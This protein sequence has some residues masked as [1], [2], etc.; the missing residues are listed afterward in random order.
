LEGAHI[1]G[2]LNLSAGTITNKNGPALNADELNLS[3]GMSCI[4]DF[5]ASGGVFL[6]G[7][8]IRGELD[9]T[10]AVLSGAVLTN[11]SRCAL[12]ADGLTV[13]GAM[14]CRQGFAANGEVSLLGARIGNQFDC[15]GGSFTNENGSALTG[16]G[17]MVDGPMFCR[18]GFVASGEVRLLGA[19]IRGQ[20]NCSGGIFANG[21]RRAF[22][23]EGVTVDGDTAFTERFEA[24]GEVL[25]LGAKIGGQLNCGG[26]TFINENGNAI[27][28]D[29]MRVGGMY[30]NEGFE[31]RGQVRFLGAQIDGQ[32]VCT[33]GV[34]T[35][36]NGMALA[37]DGLSVTGEVFCNGGFRARGEVRL[38]RAQIGG[39]LD[40]RGAILV[41]PAAC[42][43][44]VQRVSVTGSFW[45]RPAV[46]SGAVD[47]TDAQVDVYVDDPRSWPQVRRLTGFTYG[48]IEAEPPIDVKRRLEWLQR[49]EG[50][51]YSPQPYEQLA[52]VLRRRGHDGDARTVA[53]AKRTAQRHT[54]KT[55]GR[56]AN[57]FLWLT[58]GYGYRPWLAGVWLGVSVFVGCAMFHYA[59][60]SHFTAIKAPDQRPTFHASIYALEAVLPVVNLRLHDAWQPQSLPLALAA[61]ALQVAGWGLAA[62]LIA[63]VTGLIKK[64]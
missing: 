33:G 24:R 4:E 62:L 58:V 59:Y 60:P 16:D 30:C 57:I 7:A 9:L 2:Q 51:V 49:N 38:V 39:H 47:L 17:L 61:A 23:A 64:D 56:C 32:L 29:G 37:V 15:D 55:F 36:G 19:H 21:S 13:G 25:L 20:L 12:D 31:A 11:E 27:T 63:S 1:C 35:N 48:W 54:L 44:N 45:L 40:F 22:N 41:N 34:F 52:A 10:G 8:H 5:K 46:L 6:R 3:G 43:L 28:A 42:A 26:G 18:S 14:F 50:D 53:M